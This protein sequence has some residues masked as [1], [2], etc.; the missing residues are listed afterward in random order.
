M[1][2]ISSSLKEGRAVVGTII[3]TT[4]SSDVTEFIDSTSALTEDAVTSS[5]LS[6][7]E[8][9][10]DGLVCE[11]TST[12]DIELVPMIMGVLASKVMVVV[13]DADF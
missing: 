4:G 1:V 13:S 7:F 8:V 9:D 12:G 10:S 3:E 2:A 6:D 11:V 5:W